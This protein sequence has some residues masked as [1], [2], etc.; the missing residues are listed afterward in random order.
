MFLY[1][2]NCSESLSVN[3]FVSVVKDK[4]LTLKIPGLIRSFIGFYG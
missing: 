2:A 3:F 4:S 1:F